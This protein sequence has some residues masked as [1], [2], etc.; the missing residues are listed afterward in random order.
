M[1]CLGTARRL[2]GPTADADIFID[3]AGGAFDF[4]RHSSM[5]K[6]E[7]RMVVVAVQAGKRGRWT[8]LSMTFPPA[9]LIGSG[10]T[11]ARMC[12]MMALMESGRWRSI[13]LITHVFAWEQLPRLLRRRQMRLMR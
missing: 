6:I 1:E 4:G 11:R 7:C 10:A 13:P 5:G 2:S 3:A 9:C 8:S 12:G